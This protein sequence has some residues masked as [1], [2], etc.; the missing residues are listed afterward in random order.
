MLTDLRCFYSA[1]DRVAVTG[2]TGFIGNAFIAQSEPGSFLPC[3]FE[4]LPPNAIVLHLAAAVQ[5][6]RSAAA[7]NFANDLWVIE[8][9]RTKHAG[10]IY[11]S[12]NNVYPFGI[13]CRIDAAT[14]CNDYYS[15]SKVIAEKVVRDTVC[16]P[17]SI[18][19]IADVFGAGQRHGNLFRAIEKSL[20]ERDA[21]RKYG[22]GLK[23]RSYIYAPELVAMLWYVV[24]S[25]RNDMPIP[26]C[27]NACYEDSASVAEI[28][29]QISMLSGLPV[30]NVD[31]AGP[32]ASWR[33]IRTMV[34]G[35]LHGYTYKW[36][37]FRDALADYV[38]TLA[39]K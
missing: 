17:Y 13:D 39:T 28:I 29:D 32:E 33:D 15:T 14:R 2:G 35:P 11:A 23:R 19:R 5:N 7:Q 38:N 37:G 9:I 4:A 10:L 25:I 1:A 36:P 8:E 3:K 12:T 22:V 18:V 27:F 6:D 16:K 26:D 24:T 34:A 20:V 31:H 21:L 30:K